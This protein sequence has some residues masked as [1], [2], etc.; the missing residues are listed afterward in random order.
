MEPT[1]YDPKLI[2]EIRGALVLLTLLWMLTSTILLILTWRRIRKVDEKLALL[3]IVQRDKEQRTIR[4]L[5]R[6]AG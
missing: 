5:E 6:K 1:F 2:L 3:P 4:A